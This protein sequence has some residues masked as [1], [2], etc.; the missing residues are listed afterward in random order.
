[1]YY[2]GFLKRNCTIIFDLD[3]N[4]FSGA[5]RFGDTGERGAIGECGA[6]GERG[7]I[8]E[9]GDIEESS[10][11]TCRP[12]A[13]RADLMHKQKGQTQTQIQTHTQMSHKT[14]IWEN[15]FNG[16]CYLHC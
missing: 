2:Q 15:T 3:G 6:I 10:L 8:G 16:P 7:A 12:L 4:K 13:F 9:E 1:L 5:L 11:V 14:E